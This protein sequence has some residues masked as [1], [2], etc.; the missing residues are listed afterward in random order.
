MSYVCAGKSF[1]SLSEAKVFAELLFKSNGVIAAIEKP[2]A[3]KLSKKAIEAAI[4]ARVQRAVTGFL[5]PMMSIPK[6]SAVLKQAI[7]AGQSDEELKAV[8]AAFPG[9]E[10]SNI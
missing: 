2:K 10:P 9:I 8:V 4:N 3:K 1:A 5:I 7:A 6:L